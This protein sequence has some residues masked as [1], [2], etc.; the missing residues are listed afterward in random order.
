M[1]PPLVLVALGHLQQ[2]GLVLPPVPQ[3]LGHLQQEDLVLPVVPA[4]A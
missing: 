4:L 3:A 2:E 1:E